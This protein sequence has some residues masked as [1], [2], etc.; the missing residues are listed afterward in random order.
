MMKV[1][2]VSFLSL[3]FVASSP[4]STVDIRNFKWVSKR[5]S[6]SAPPYH[7]V[8]GE[9]RAT[10]STN[11][12]EGRLTM[13][14]HHWSSGSLPLIGSP[15]SASVVAPNTANYVPFGEYDQARY[16]GYYQASLTV[17]SY[18]PFAPDPTVHAQDT[19]VSVIAGP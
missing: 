19:E 10:W 16:W 2:L 1:I 13:G 3:G 8:R 18:G 6:P 9:Y 5:P 14:W 7:F 12:V 4:G 17:F 15:D 11:N